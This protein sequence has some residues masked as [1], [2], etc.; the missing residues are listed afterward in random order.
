MKKY[1]FVIASLLLIGTATTQVLKNKKY[2]NKNKEHF[3]IKD[4]V[5]YY[6]EKPLAK[7]QAKTYSLDN[8]ELVEEYN[9]LLL[10]N[11]IT[12][13]QLIGDLIDYIS[14][15]HSGAEVEV[16]IDANGSVFEL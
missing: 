14:D 10:D 1:L 15:R 5:V 6:D 4:R 7:Y 13:K 16:E 9:M 12:N 11:Q 3:T 8:N 2:R